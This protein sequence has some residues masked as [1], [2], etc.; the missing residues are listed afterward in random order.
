MA[1]LMPSR[2]GLTPGQGLPSLPYLVT[3]PSADAP[4]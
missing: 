2:W 1:N 3:F 4:Q